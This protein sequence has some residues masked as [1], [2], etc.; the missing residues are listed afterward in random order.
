[1]KKLALRT[2]DGVEINMYLTPSEFEGKIEHAIL[3]APA[4]GVPA[5]FYDQF[6]KYFAKCG[7]D[8]FSFDYRT[9]GPKGSEYPRLLDVG[10]YDLDTAIEHLI[11][12]Y[13]KVSYIGHSLGGQLLGLAKSANKLDRAVF[14]A[15]SIPDT[16]NMVFKLRWQTRV[17]KY[18]LLPFYREKGLF[19][20]RKLGL[21][22]LDLPASIANDWGRWLRSKSYLFDHLTNEQLSCYRQVKI[23]ILSIGFSD[24]D[25]APRK[26]LTR[27]LQMYPE[28][29]VSMT[30]HNVDS[31][32][33]S[34]GH[35]GFFRESSGLAYWS[36]TL[37]WISSQ[38]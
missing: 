16:Q 33:V 5:K 9:V 38:K 22:S 2:R 28:E 27:L 23:P 6:A 20:S 37:N 11:R 17:L 8:V 31:G 10:V 36:S 26:N 4:L 14:I 13:R 35:M 12:K 32:K 7:I 1:M 15:S 30:F 25:M 24:D 34:C 18:F 21:S 19:P 3:I 29:Q